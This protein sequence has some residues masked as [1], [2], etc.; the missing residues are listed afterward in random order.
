MSLQW[1][2]ARSGP[3]P[4]QMNPLRAKNSATTT[5][6]SLSTCPKMRN[7]PALPSPSIV[8]QA[9]EPSYAEMARNPEAVT[10]KPPVETGRTQAKVAPV[11]R[12]ETSKYPVIIKSQDGPVLFSKLGSWRQAQPLKNTVGAVQSIQRLANAE[13]LIG[14]ANPQQQRK[15]HP[16]SSLP[17]EPGRPIK[18]NT[19]IPQKIVIGVIKGVPDKPNAKRLLRDDLAQDM[20][21]DSIK[22]LQ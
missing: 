14:C 1:S 15:L 19:R 11:P 9:S 16:A 12:S 5:T 21:T 18:I 8:Q 10:K 13:W 17:G 22:R 4:H 20:P 7:Q 2:G 3:A 6:P